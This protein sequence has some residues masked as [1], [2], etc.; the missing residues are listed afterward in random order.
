MVETVIVFFF[1]NANEN[2][3][4]QAELLLIYFEN[5]MFLFALCVLL[6]KWQETFYIWIYST[7]VRAQNL[8]FSVLNLISKSI[9]MFWSFFRMLVENKPDWSGRW[10]HL[11]KLLMRSGPLAHQDFEPGSQVKT[12]STETNF[13]PFFPEPSL[14]FNMAYL[15]DHSVRL[16]I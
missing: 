4:S 3:S 1:D 14:L 8:L 7:F 10:S 12:F 15:E 11:Q 5:T 16:I 2:N 6:M 13:Y 9:K